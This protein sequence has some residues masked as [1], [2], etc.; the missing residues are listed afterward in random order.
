[1]VY[2]FAD[3]ELD[4]QLYQLWRA[5]APVAVEP[6]VFDVLVYL[7][8]WEQAIRAYAGTKREINE[9]ARQLFE[10]AIALDPHYAL[11]Y[12]GLGMTYWRDWYLR[13][14][15]DPAQSMQRAME[16]ARHAITLDDTLPHARTSL[17]VLYMWQKQLP[18]AIAEAE[19]AIALDPNFAEGFSILGNILIFAGRPQE[20]I[21]LIEKAIRLNPRQV[22]AYSTSLPLAYRD[23]GRYED[24]ITSAQKILAV[25]PDA[26]HYYFTLAFC[27]AQLGQETDARAAVEKIRQLQPSASLEWVQKTV[28]YA[29][30]ADLERLVA[31]LRKAGLK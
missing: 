16:F 3:C 21:E 9:Q 2:R 17:G 22:G 13:W 14:S 31:G 24:A 11:A 10:Q 12:T 5:G 23:A 29:N 4:E 8:G 18:Q 27:F 19:R 28:P 26:V 20:S 25:T 30:P 15:S 7:R 6:K 1:M